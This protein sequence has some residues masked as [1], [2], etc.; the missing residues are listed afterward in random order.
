[1]AHNLARE[2]RDEYLTRFGNAYDPDR[3]PSPETTPTDRRSLIASL[4]VCDASA[5]QIDIHHELQ[6]LPKSGDVVILDPDK[7]HLPKEHEE[8]AAI[9]KLWSPHSKATS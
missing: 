4:K 8:Q 1:M 6:L 7:E 5:R 2:K 3:Y 9:M